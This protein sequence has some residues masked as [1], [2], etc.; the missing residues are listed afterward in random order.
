MAE[1]SQPKEGVE[2][3]GF[4]SS[5]KLFGSNSLFFFLLI[6]LAIQIG[7]TLWEN[8]QRS[9]EHDEIVCATK[10]AIFVYST[11]RAGEKFELDFQRLPVDLYNCLPRFL[12]EKR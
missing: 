4:G 10:L 5:L 1:V 3:T 8:V 2:F 7:V 11:P 12:Y 6:V 9:R